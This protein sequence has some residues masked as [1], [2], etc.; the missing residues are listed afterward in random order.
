MV[1]LKYLRIISR[2][3]ETPLINCEINLD[4]NWLKKCIIV[5]AAILDQGAT[6]SITDAKLYV[7]VV[8]L[9]TQDNEKLLEQL[10]HVFK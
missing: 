5:A 3:L 7:P 2:T 1:H 10:K 8:A 9:S 6:F 4:L